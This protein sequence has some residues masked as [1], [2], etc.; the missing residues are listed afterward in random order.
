MNYVP[1]WLT[2]NASP[3][4]KQSIDIDMIPLLRRYRVRLKSRLDRHTPESTFLDS[5]IRPR[6]C[7]HQSGVEC[8]R[9][10]LREVVDR[11]HAV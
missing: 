9:S 4:E 5:E 1:E 10:D 8:D 2:P 11:R 7:A 6:L 3:Q